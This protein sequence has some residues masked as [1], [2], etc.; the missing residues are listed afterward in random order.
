M[1]L[2]LAVEYHGSVW[3]VSAIPGTPKLRGGTW[4]SPEAAFWGQVRAA[5]NVMAR[6]PADH[7][8][9]VNPSRFAMTGARY[10]LAKGRKGYATMLIDGHYAIRCP[11]AEVNSGGTVHLSYLEE[12]P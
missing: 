7:W 9:R 6:S 3:S 1:V 12:T 4:G 2:K 5:V 10:A 8:R 11:A